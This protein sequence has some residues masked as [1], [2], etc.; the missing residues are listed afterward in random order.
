MGMDLNPKVR[1]L[2]PTKEDR[3]N[4][5]ERQRDRLV[6]EIQNLMEEGKFGKLG[7]KGSARELRESKEE[8]GSWTFW[9]FKHGPDVQIGQYAMEGRVSRIVANWKKYLLENMKYYLIQAAYD[10]A[11]NASK[12]PVALKTVSDFIGMNKNDEKDTKL[13]L[14]RKF[15]SILQRGR[16]GVA[17]RIGKDNGTSGTGNTGHECSNTVHIVADGQQADIAVEAV[18]SGHDPVIYGYDTVG[19]IPEGIAV[20]DTEGSPE[21]AVDNDSGA[22]LGIIE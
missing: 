15:D 1:E 8:D 14:P 7:Q 10:Q 22:D 13:T 6:I 19:D 17:I 2:L 11:K 5:S 21:D 16:V 20:P 12:S 4:E 3:H 18:S 9:D